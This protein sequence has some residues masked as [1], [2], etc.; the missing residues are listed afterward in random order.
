MAKQPVRGLEVGDLLPALQCA[1]SYNSVTSLADDAIAGRPLL[2]TLIHAPSD[3]Q[4]DQIVASI[5]NWLPRLSALD[6]AVYLVLPMT[7]QNAR[8]WAASA[9]VTIP[10]LADGDGKL[11]AALSPKEG[12][13]APAVSL[14]FR[15]N[16][17]VQAI[18]TDSNDD[19]GDTACAF[20]ETLGAERRH[21]QGE[22]HAPVLMVP[23]V[24]SVKDCQRLMT[25]YAMQGNEFVEPG[26]GSQNRTQDY[27]MKIPDYGRND[28]V[29]HWVISKDTTA[30]VAGRLGARVIPEIKKAFHYQITKYE[31]FRIGRYQALDSAE[32]IVGASNGHRDNTEPQVA[33]R[34]F[35]CS[36][37]LNSESFEGGGLTFPEFGGQEYSP[38]TGEALVF[39]SSLLHHVQPV[40]KGTRFVLLSFLFGDT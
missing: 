36:V 35:A 11:A 39:S 16:H 14:L 24:F 29:D 40:T 33:Y 4:S 18:L 34:R 9:G 25:V 12:A 2:L 28:R 37:N 31:R 10:C 38:R 3:P 6:C 32:G 22:M 7:P 27:K 13:A 20:I 8:A 26:H 21:R 17:H 30:F 23:D 1:D 15:P 5:A 19:H